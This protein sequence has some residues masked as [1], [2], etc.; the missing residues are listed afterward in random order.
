MQRGLAEAENEMEAARQQAADLADRLAA[1]R[2]RD[3]QIQHLW[4]ANKRQNWA[5]RTIQSH[6]RLW[7]MN[8]LHNHNHYHTHVRL[9]TPQAP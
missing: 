7:R 2:I 9:H 1:I 3:E 8:R 6:F 4:C 5:A